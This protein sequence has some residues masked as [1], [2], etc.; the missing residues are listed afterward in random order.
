MLEVDFDRCEANGVC[1][2]VAPQVFDLDD[3]DQLVVSDTAD[4]PENKADVDEA[5]AGCPRAALRWKG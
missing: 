2:G 4:L 1:V 3:D 5:I